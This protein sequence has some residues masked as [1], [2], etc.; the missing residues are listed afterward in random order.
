LKSGHHY[1]KIIKEHIVM[2]SYKTSYFA[3]VFSTNDDLIELMSCINCGWKVRGGVLLQ[4]ITSS[5]AENLVTIYH[6][7]NTGHQF[8]IVKELTTILKSVRDNS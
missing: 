1:E 4:E 3:I 7:L 2:S 5:Y 6:L 8:T